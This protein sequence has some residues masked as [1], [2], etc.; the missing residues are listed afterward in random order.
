MPFDLGSVVPL[1]V[2]VTDSAGAAA[3][4]GTVVLTVTLPDQTTA[5]PTITNSVTGTYTADY[6]TTQ[7]GRHIARWVATGANAS[8]YVDAFDVRPAA[9]VG[10]ISLADAKKHL[11]MTST[12]NDDELRDH[13]A[14]ATTVVEYYVGPVDV[15][16]ATE[17]VPGGTSLIL[18]RTPAISLTSV[19][20]VYTVGLTYVVADLDLDGTTG[21]VRHKLGWR[22]IGPLRVVYQVGRAI[23]PAN[24]QM[25]ARIIIKHLWETQRGGS[26]RPG[27]GQSDDIVEQQLVS[28]MG[29][30]IPRRAVELLQTDPHQT[31]GFA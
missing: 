15:T 7:A 10:I 16:T 3:N 8:S 2:K 6:T 13:I 25:A 18:S 12:S 20:P 21:I 29:F 19:E 28:V 4:A 14:S 9:I 27:M 26:R 24:Q 31:L 5:T 23:V 11:N 1:S 17:V 30:A 22:F